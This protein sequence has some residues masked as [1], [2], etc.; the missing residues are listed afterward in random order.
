MYNWMDKYT[1]TINEICGAI[2]VKN[3][4]NSNKPRIIEDLKLIS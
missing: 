1:T 3:K 2:I 4:A